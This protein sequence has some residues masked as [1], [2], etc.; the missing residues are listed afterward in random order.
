MGSAE[1]VALQRVGRLV[2]AS[3]GGVTAGLSG[4]TAVPVVIECAAGRADGGLIIVR[5]T[6]S[7]AR[8]PVFLLALQLVGPGIGRFGARPA[9]EA[10]VIALGG[11]RYGRA[12]DH[13]QQSEAD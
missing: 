8:G 3:A 12:G 7:G 10:V 1:I 6:A 5:L 9:I 13:G 4:V 11:R 2:L